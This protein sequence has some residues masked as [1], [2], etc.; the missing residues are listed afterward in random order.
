MVN[1]ASLKAISAKAPAIE[2]RLVYSSTASKPTI[3]DAFKTQLL[4]PE[5]VNKEI[6]MFRKEAA[7][8]KEFA[9]NILKTQAEKEGLSVFIMGKKAGETK[10]AYNLRLKEAEDCDIFISARVKDQKSGYAKVKK[11]I[12][13]LGN[14]ENVPD[15]EMQKKYKKS[16]E[17][18]NHFLQEKPLREKY[19]ALI[20]DQLGLRYIQ[21]RPAA[22]GK[23][24]TDTITNNL[25]SLHQGNK[26]SLRRYENYKGEGITPY[27][28]FERSGHVRNLKYID[29][30][31]IQQNVIYAEAIKPL[32]YTRINADAKINN[33]NTEIQIGGK[34]STA[35][36]EIEHVFYDA[37]SNKP[38]NT[39]GMTAEQKELAKKIVKEYK[40]VLADESA[41]KT[42]GQYLRDIWK[43]AIDAEELIINPSFKPVPNGFSPILSAEN[44]FSL[45][46]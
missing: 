17:M 6:A 18:I 25:S 28:T 26:L 35:V 31:G 46:H 12:S 19:K 44:I 30:N 2:G 4:N 22:N 39:K 21:N 40:K 3:M 23:N 38:I 10:A 41:N 36:G 13:D 34:H 33:V 5:R 11:Q 9:E 14:F 29:E 24:V 1:L 45:K 15:E 32:G 37:R 20:G 43:T 7:P 16:H 8:Q 27:T 42:F